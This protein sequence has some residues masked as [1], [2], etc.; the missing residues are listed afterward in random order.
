[1]PNVFEPELCRDLIADYEAGEPGESCVLRA[2]GHVL[3]AGFKQRRDHIVA[4]PQ[5]VRAAN[6]RIN[7]RVRPEVEQVFYMKT[8]FI[9][10]HV[11]TPPMAVIPGRIATMDRGL[12]RTAASP[13]RSIST[14]ASRAARWCF[15]STALRVTRHRRAGR[16]CSLAASCTRCARVT[17]GA[18]YA[19][20]PF[21]FDEAGTE[22]R[23]AGVAKAGLS[24]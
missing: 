12:Q 7:R 10:R 14:A 9:E 23:R 11:M 20:L 19:F 13:F 22:I 17:A 5:L 24:T 4:N 8:P 2:G 18:R 6:I 21:V 15:P 16:S 3:D 1:L